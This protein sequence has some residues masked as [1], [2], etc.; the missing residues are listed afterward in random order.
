MKFKKYIKLSIVLFICLFSLTSCSVIRSFIGETNRIVNEIENHHIEYSKDI[1]ITDIE[2]ALTTASSI[3]KSCTIGVSVTNESF[4]TT[5]TSSGSAVIVKRTEN[6]DGGYSYYAITNRH[7]TG[8]KATKQIKVYIGEN[9]NTYI[10]AK[11]VAYDERYD[12]ALISFDSAYILGVANFATTELKAGQFAIAVGSPYDLEAYYNTVTVGSVSSPLRYH[13]E[14]DIYGN[15]YKNEFIQHDA[16]INS[17]NSGGGLYDIYGNLIGINTW[18]IVGDM[19]DSIEGLS[20]AIP[21][22]IVSE[23]FARYLK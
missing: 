13:I 6:S 8:Y 20:F 9:I 15:N 2:E 4:I 11:L 1:T 7:V 10:N 5:S 23:R 3:A 16:S 19:D 12:L 22:R 14:E 18:K 17:G 21:A